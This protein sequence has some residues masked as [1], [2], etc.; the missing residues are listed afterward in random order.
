[1]TRT[2]RR[3]FARRIRR[4]TETHRRPVVELLETRAL[5]SFITT[6]AAYFAGTNARAVVT[7]DLNGDSNQDLA[8]TNN[9]SAGTVSILLG[10]A[11]GS[12]SGPISFAVGV[13][14]QALALGD[15]T[16]DAKLDLVVANN[17]SGTMSFLRGRGDGT[18]QPAVS[19][20][21]GA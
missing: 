19:I 20:L 18:F 15:F 11:D 5:P 10:N 7:G 14:P 3:P 8:V 12:F 17:G 13:N 9:V 6:P 4:A 1:M 21:C 2:F 16:G